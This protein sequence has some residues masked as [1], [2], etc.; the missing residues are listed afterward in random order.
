MVESAL[1]VP[2]VFCQMNKLAQVQIASNSDKTHRLV[3]D[4]HDV[5]MIAERVELSIDAN[6]P[7]PHAM[8]NVWIP[9]SLVMDIP[10]DL[11]IFVDYPSETSEAK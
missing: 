9:A 7:Y 5:S 1:V 4:G 10:A 2:Q 3:I 8:V 11:V 6:S